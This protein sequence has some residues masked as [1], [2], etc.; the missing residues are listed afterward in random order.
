MKLSWKLVFALGT[1]ALIRPLLNGTGIMGIIGQP[2]GSLAVT[3]SITVIWIAAV[4]WREEA[5]PVL[6]LTGAGFFYGLLAIVISAFLSPIINGELQGPLTS[7]FAVSGVFFTNMVWGASA[8]LVALLLMK[9]M[10]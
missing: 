3:F 7:P 6:T 9:W 4:I 2:L 5:R 8:G 10:R 1:L